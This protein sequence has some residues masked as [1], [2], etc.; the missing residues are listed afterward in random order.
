MAYLN[1]KH[2]E[3][4]LWRCWSTYSDE[5]ITNWMSETD[6][7]EYLIQRAVEEIK[8]DLNIHGIRT[9]NFYTYEEC[10]YIEALNNYCSNC[11]HHGDFNACDSC[12]KNITVKAYIEQGDDY[13]NLGIMNK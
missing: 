4:K 6:Y 12:D 2:P 10:L 7:K 8:D 1:I 13:F 3:T 5:W 11:P 9:S